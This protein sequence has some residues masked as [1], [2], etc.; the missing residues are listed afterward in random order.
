METVGLKYAILTKYATLE[1]CAKAI[2]MSK[3]SF[4]RALRNPSTRFLNKLSKAGIEIERPQDVIK[5]SEPDEKELLIRE[6]KGII[7]EKN[8]LIEEQKSIIEQ[9]DLMIK[10]YEELNKT[11]KAKKK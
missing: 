6:L 2:G 1:Q 9:K 3:S 7:Y 5:K 10:Q 4:S 11:I 8:A